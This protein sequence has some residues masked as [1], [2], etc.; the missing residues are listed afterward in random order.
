VLPRPHSW[1]VPA[2]LLAAFAAFSVSTARAQTPEGTVITNTATVTYTDANSN[3]YSPVSASVSV[4][5]GFAGGISLTGT[6]SVNPASPST[7]DTLLFTYQNLG[8]GNDSLRVTESISVGGIIT[9]TGYRVNAT[10]YATLDDLNAALSGIL[11]ARINTLQVRVVYNVAT[12]MGGV[13]TN[14]TLT[15]FSRRDGSKT[16]AAMTTINP[17]MTAGVAITPDLGQNLQQLPSNATNYT[18]TFA[19]QNTGTGPDNINLVASHPGVAVSIVSVNGV[20]G[21]STSIALASNASRDVAVVY[22]VLDVAAE[23]KDTVVLTGTS[24]ANNAVSDRGSADLTVIKPALTVTKVAYRD[25]QTTPIGAGL[26]LPGEFVQYK[27]TVTN[28]GAG[29]A[30]SVQISDAL[31]AQLTFASASA[32]AAGWTIGNVG[33]SVTATL[34]GSLASAGSRYIWIRAQVN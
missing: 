5:V 4:T 29:E 21:T 25:D 9:V 28:G 26:V 12:G 19:V 10:T 6:A 32:D 24:V 30:T 15:G 14:Y 33:N 34:S 27:V 31:P 2:V 18:F 17:A 23:T 8:N 11:V 16:Q 7:A 1:R 13:P 20:A 22:T 3:S